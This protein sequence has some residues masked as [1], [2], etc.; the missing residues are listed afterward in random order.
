MPTDTEEPQT[1]LFADIGKEEPGPQGDLFADIGE[2]IAPTQIYTMP[3]P[4]PAPREAPL[5]FTEAA[6]AEDAAVKAF[7]QREQKRTQLGAEQFALEKQIEAEAEPSLLEKGMAAVTTPLKEIVPT[8]DLQPAIERFLTLASP[9]M[10]AAIVRQRALAGEPLPDIIPPETHKAIAIASGV[11]ESLANTVNFFTSPLG[12]ATLGMGALPKAAHAA[13]AMAFAVQ[14][15]QAV[16]EIATQLGDEL[17]KPESERN[18]KK[19]AALTTE[20]ITATGFAA[21][22]ARGAYRQIM[23]LPTLQAIEGET[24][25]NRMA[26]LRAQGIAED[27]A[28]RPGFGIRQWEPGF[29]ARPPGESVT[30]G[31][32]PIPTPA[33]VRRLQPPLDPLGPPEMLGPPPPTPWQKYN[34]NFFKMVNR[35][36]E[37]GDPTS[38]RADIQAMFPEMFQGLERANERAGLLAK[39]AWGDQWKP[40]AP[41]VKA[42]AEAALPE[43]IIEPKV[44]AKPA[45][46]PPLPPTPP[47]PAAPVA[48]PAPDAP[49]PGPPRSPHD[50]EPALVVDGVPITGGDDHEAIFNRLKEEALAKGDVA[51]VIKLVNIFGDDAAHIFVDKERNP[52]S[53][54]EAGKA[55]GLDYPLQSSELLRLKGRKPSAV[56]PPTPEPEETVT[57]FPLGKPPT[58]EVPLEQIQSSPDLP[59]FKADADPVTGVVPGQR[60]EGTYERRGTAPV[61]LWRRTDGNLYIITGRHRLDLARRTGE[62]TI[63]AQIMEEAKGFT[64]EMALV[65]DAEANI[66]DGQGTVE[67]YAHYF[68]NIQGLT[69]QEA[70]SRGLLSRAKG[71]AGWDL[72]KIASDDLYASWK[73]GQISEAQALAICRAAPGNPGAQAVGLRFA[74]RVKDPD[75]LGALVKRAAETTP[76]EGQTGDLFGW[77]DSALREMEKDQARAEKIMEDIREDI[78]ALRSA[79]RPERAAKYGIDIKDPASVQRIIGELQAQLDRWKTWWLQPDLVE[80]VK[81]KPAAPPAAPP[82]APP[83]PAPAPAPAPAPPAPKPEEPKPAPA[84][85]AAPAPAPAGPPV[86]DKPTLDIFSDQAA[87]DAEARLRERMGKKPPSAPPPQPPPQAPP[88]GIQMAAE[89]PQGELFPGEHPETEDP[90]FVEAILRDLTAI[91]GNIIGHGYLD[92]SAWY[93]QMAERFPEFKHYFRRAYNQVR[94]VSTLRDLSKRMT[95]REEVELYNDEGIK[96]GKGSKHRPGLQVRSED[97]IPQV[98]QVVT[99]GM[100]V[101]PEG[102]SIDWTQALAINLGVEAHRTGKKGIMLAD[103]PGVGKSGMGAM[104]AHLLTKPTRVPLAEDMAPRWNE[105]TD[106]ERARWLGTPGIK[107]IDKSLTFDKLTPEERRQVYQNAGYSHLQIGQDNVNAGKPADGDVLVVGTSKPHLETSFIPDFHK[108]GIPTDHIDFVTYT[109][110]S[111][112]ESSEPGSETRKLYEKI[113]SKRYKAVVFDEAHAFKNA[114]SSREHNSRKIQAEFKVFMTATPD[115]QPSERNLFHVGNHRQDPLADHGS[116]GIEAGRASRQRRGT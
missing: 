22:G 36:R 89:A 38:T 106:Q 20:A 13:I 12:I 33:E 59:N 1:D 42:R 24:A 72:A 78:R 82:P 67:D 65:F 46:P 34:E 76:T 70:R 97:L 11:E 5:P 109:V 31:L 48:P 57:G 28:T 73:A 116:T 23:G 103:G 60:L 41:E 100:Y 44:E 51:R 52:Y 113:T 75:A 37:S 29:E 81:G 93:R 98:P 19:I 85:P 45:E 90:L 4:P 43:A 94:D 99:P 56:T 95:P 92:Y 15:S 69:E 102:E 111:I 55:L 6:A 110:L 115:G 91:G 96:I 53:R 74:K 84:P 62:K 88:P 63:P 108:F 105:G 83:P 9:T 10:P 114:G 66:R 26:R 30:F 101:G 54:I 16:P 68:K 71:R 27:I 50:F 40:V 86:P 21:G 18:Y 7:F 14:M 79:K 107:S 2:D 61:V 47:A 112:G 77:N 35:L 39:H 80:Q 49:P 25:A 3:T 8:T 104:I 64:K 58:V 32:G 17:G 87:R